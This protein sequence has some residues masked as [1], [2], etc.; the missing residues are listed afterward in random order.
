MKEN[1]AKK[2]KKQ[3]V[4]SKKEKFRFSNIMKNYFSFYNQNLKKKQI[5]MYIIILVLFGIFM[6]NIISQVDVTKTIANQSVGTSTFL[7]ILKE[8]VLFTLLIIVAGITPYL[9]IPV[10]AALFIPYVYAVDILNVINNGQGT[11]SLVSTSISAVLQLLGVSLAVA[12]GIYYCIN[13]TKKYRY[14]QKKSFGMFDLKKQVYEI[15]KDEDKLQKLMDDRQKTVEKNEKLNVK[16]DYM[17]ILISGIISLFIV[18][19][20]SLITLI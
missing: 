2:I 10:I 3:V 17:N 8:K 13:T 9:Y 14:S 12:T 5:I 7:N 20:S 4:N 15:R 19:L 11:V 18:A 16:I 6:T 1:E